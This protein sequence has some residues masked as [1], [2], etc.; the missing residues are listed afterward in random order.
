MDAV[1]DKKADTEF[2]NVRLLSD[3]T[4]TQAP[5]P[6]KAL[7]NAV[8]RFE[9]EIEKETMLDSVFGALKIK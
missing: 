5:A 1:S 9:G 4:K 3:V 2:D 7:E 8:V 6:I